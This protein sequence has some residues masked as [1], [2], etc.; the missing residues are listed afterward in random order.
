MW[1]WRAG[2]IRIHCVC[3]RACGAGW[4]RCRVFA[5][6]L[7]DGLIGFSGPYKAVFV[8]PVRGLGQSKREADLRGW[9]CRFAPVSL[10]PIAMNS[11][12]KFGRI[13]GLGRVLALTEVAVCLA[14]KKAA[15][16]CGGAAWAHGE[17]AFTGRRGAAARTEPCRRAVPAG[18]RVCRLS[19][20]SWLCWRR[21]RIRRRC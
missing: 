11:G 4:P 10:R 18:S 12:A 6:R 21:L 2:F 8:E 3:L 7:E 9:K 5:F 1:R 15:L 16:L 13:A 14:A 17:G 19:R 20:L